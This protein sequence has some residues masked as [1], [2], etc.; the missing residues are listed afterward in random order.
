MKNRFLL[1]ENNTE[2]MIDIIIYFLY[3]LN[4]AIFARV[5]MSWVIPSG[6]SSNPLVNII[7][8]ITEPILSPIRKIVP[9]VGMFDFTPMIAVV[10]LGIIISVLGG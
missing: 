4:L 8:E 3:L 5:I 6:Q 10:P 9:R 2:F 7:H 1:E